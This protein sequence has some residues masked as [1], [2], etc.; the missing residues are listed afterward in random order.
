MQAGPYR[1]YTREY[2]WQVL[3]RLKPTGMMTQ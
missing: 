2:Y 1:L 3:G